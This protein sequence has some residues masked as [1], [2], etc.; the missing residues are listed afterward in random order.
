VCFAGQEIGVDCA[1]I[2]F[3]SCTM[4]DAPDGSFLAG[5][6]IC[7]APGGVQDGGM[8]DGSALHADGGD[9]STVDAH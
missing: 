5:A 1:A 3:G 2:G 9:A 4:A 7:G 6:A 8:H